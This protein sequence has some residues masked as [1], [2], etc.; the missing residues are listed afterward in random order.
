M[1]CG[2]TPGL[3]GVVYPPFV[4]GRVGTFVSSLFL[5]S[6]FSSLFL[7]VA[8]GTASLS[9]RF[10]PWQIDKPQ[11]A[12][13]HKDVY[14]A[15]LVRDTARVQQAFLVARTR[16]G[17]HL[18]AAPTSTARGSMHRSRSAAHLG[19]HGRGLLL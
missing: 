3:V 13:G 11:A 9:S 15:T 18:R 8:S 16:T 5:C 6:A 1:A 2:D 10:W 4:S 7:T 19:S 12:G 17:A 14:R